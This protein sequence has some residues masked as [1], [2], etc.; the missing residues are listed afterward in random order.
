MEK[1]QEIEILYRETPIPYYIK[2]DRH[3]I[4]EVIQRYKSDGFY[5]L[6]MDV[7]I[8]DLML[9]GFWLDIFFSPDIIGA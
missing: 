3:D 1:H 6:T 5:T 9:A 7:I 2:P 4:V 8:K